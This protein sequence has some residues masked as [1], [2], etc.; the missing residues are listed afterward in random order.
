MKNSK[1][2]NFADYQL[3]CLRK[4][5]R[6]ERKLEKIDEFV[7]WSALVAEVKVIDKTGSQ[8]GRPRWETEMM[9]K[10]LFVQYL[11]NLSDPELEDQVNDRLSFQ[12]FTGID[13]NRKVPDYSTVWRFKE[14]LIEEDLYN[15]LFE[16]INQQIEQR[17]LFLKKGSVVDATIIESDNRPLSEK[18]R[19]ELEE[20]PSSQIDTDAQSTCKNGDYYYGYKGHIGTDV[21]SKLIRNK[22]FTPANRHDIT[23]RDRLIEGDER[24]VFGDKAYS[25]QE[26]KKE[27]RE[28]DIYYGILDKGK[29]GH[30]LSRTQQK[31]N[32]KHSRVRASV[33]HPFAYMRRILHYNIA[34]ATTLVRNE[35]RF[36]MNCMIYN[37]M[38]AGYLEQ[39][40]D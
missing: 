10:L 15:K 21:D 13:M 30:P 5:T 17:G 31:Q 36:T 38:R 40:M 14:A 6:T 32:E 24:A 37:I 25:E 3:N 33:E 20:E 29:R 9:L 7:D 22:S 1:Q 39:R 27:C 28:K 18:R 23:Q 8:G 26:Y 19:E 34:Q 11:Y 35:L 16:L 2:L 4:K 12:R